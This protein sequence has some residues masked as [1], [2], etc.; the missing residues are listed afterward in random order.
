MVEGDRMRGEGTGEG[1]SRGTQGDH[2]CCSKFWSAVTLPFLDDTILQQ[3]SLTCG[4]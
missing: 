1:G 4:Y 3:L 2:S